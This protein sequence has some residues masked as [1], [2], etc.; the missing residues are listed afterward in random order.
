MNP[1]VQLR[2]FRRQELPLIE[3]W[4]SDGETR[5]WLVAP[6]WRRRMLDFADRPLGVFRG[7]RETGFVRWLAWDGEVPVGYLDCGT[8]DRWTTWDGQRVVGTIEVPSG[9]LA[10]T[11]APES[12]GRG[13]GRRMLHAL[14]EAPDLTDIEIFALGSSRRTC[15]A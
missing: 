3:L 14:L 12:R 5:R 2:S 7:A 13:Y 8:Y 11:V 10:L 6:D 1:D 15:P 9:A 4:F